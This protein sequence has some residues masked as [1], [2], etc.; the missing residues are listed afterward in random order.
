MRWV[1]GRVWVED[2]VA[3]PRAP[4]VE[5]LR[6]GF[7][8]GTADMTLGIVQAR[9][10]SLVA[11]PLELLRFGDPQTTAGGVS[12]AIEGG[13]LAAEPGGR[14]SVSIDDTRIVARVE[15]Y[16]PAL[17]RGVYQ[18]TQLPLH[19]ALVRL[20]LLRLRGRRPAPGV[21]A[22]VSSRLAA[23]AI[24][25]A[26]CGALTLLLARRRRVR[27]FVALTAGYHVAAWSVSGRTIG[28]ALFR[29]R[30]VAVD[31]SRPTPVQALLRLIA[32]PFAGIRFRAIHDEVAGTEVVAEAFQS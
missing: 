12:W 23:G 31:G 4:T 25:V 16:R 18:L 32:L 22:D 5:R 27:A 28:G 14:L 29:Q 10:H 2:A 1:D 19:H 7:M 17:P 21:P 30:V 3:S 24:D 9:D 11:G 6:N 20:V 8:R 26:I 13:V 15:G